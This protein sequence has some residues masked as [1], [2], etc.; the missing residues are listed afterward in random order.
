MEVSETELKTAVQALTDILDEVQ[1]M[2]IDPNPE[3]STL[4][5]NPESGIPQQYNI[6]DSRM[7]DLL[8]EEAPP[9]SPVTAQ[10][11]KMLDSPATSGFSRAPGDG[12]PPPA[13]SSGQSGRK[14][15]GRP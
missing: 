5:N 8:D 7:P 15:T 3:S 11:N 6:F 9:A 14:I 4:G 2:D 1:P 13:S 10:E 12:R